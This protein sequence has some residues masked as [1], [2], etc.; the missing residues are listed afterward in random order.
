MKF[1]IGFGRNHETDPSPAN[2]DEGTSPRVAKFLKKVEEFEEKVKKKISPS[3]L[4]ALVIGNDTDGLKEFLRP[5]KVL[6]YFAICIYL[7]F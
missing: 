7:L 3:E 6:T 2:V 1:L 4:N 5:K